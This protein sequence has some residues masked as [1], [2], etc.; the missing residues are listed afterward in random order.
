MHLKN[1]P[2]LEGTE[3]AREK[4]RER[5]TENIKQNPENMQPGGKNLK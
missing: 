1:R 5:N 4:M 3:K 2:R